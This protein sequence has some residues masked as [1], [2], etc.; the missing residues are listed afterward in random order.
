MAKDFST[1]ITGREETQKR[2]QRLLKVAPQLTKN[3]VNEHAINIQAQAKRNITD[4]PAVDTGQLRS[5]VKIET[6]SSGF[7][8]RVGSDVKHAKPI[9]F[10]TGPHFPPLEPIQEWA[11]RHGLPEEAAYPIA[12]AI[13]ERGTPAKA[14]LFPA[15]EQERPKFEAVIRD[16]WRAI[17]GEL[18]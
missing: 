15:F 2:I 12:K 1:T 17:Q 6:F 13:S 7:A 16:A 8:K 10:G 9:E 4:A 5:S 18:A 11:R 14:W 3:A